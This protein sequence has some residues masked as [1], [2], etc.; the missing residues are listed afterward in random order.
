ML[1]RDF[2]STVY[3][4]VDQRLASKLLWDSYLI[5]TINFALS[6]IYSYQWKHWTFMFWRQDLEITEEM[7]EDQLT[8]TLD[9]PMM[10]LYHIEDLNGE[11]DNFTLTNQDFELEQWV[12]FFRPHENVLKI[13]NNE[14]WYILHYIHSF[15]WVGLDDEIPLPDIFLAPLYNKILTYI[16]PQYGQYWDG[17]DANS[18]SKYMEQMQN[19][20]MMD[21]LQV[22]WVTT[23]I[24]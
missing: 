16:Y 2:L 1:V 10:R 4:G 22:T 14:K 11:F 5:S 21:S 23:N 8:F 15:N 7:V 3:K 12:I 9:Y 19:F 13:K 24:H 17:K 20:A 18:Q 6:D